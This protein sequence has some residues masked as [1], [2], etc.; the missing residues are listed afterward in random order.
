MDTFRQIQDKILPRENL[1][2][3]IAHIRKQGYSIGFTNGCFDILHKG[4]IQYLAHAADLADILIIGLNTDKSVQV[5]KGKN[6]P[7]QD[8]DTR[9]LNLASLLFVDFVV[10]FHED[11][12]YE[13]IRIIEPDFL[14]KGGEYSHQEIVGNDIVTARGGK[15]LT[16]PMI[17]GYST[18]SIIEK[19]SRIDKNT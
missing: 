17:E 10:M 8:Q 9:A 3:T 19:I 15:V 7:I 4:H 12:P 6:R 13:I 18:T 14:I 11:T 16:V 1:A 2:E 5:I